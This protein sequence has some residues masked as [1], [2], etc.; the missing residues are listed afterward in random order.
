MA[1]CGITAIHDVPTIG[2]PKKGF[3][4][5]N[6]GR[7]F[8]MNPNHIMNPNQIKYAKT[9]EWVA[10]E[11]DLAIIGISDFAVKTLTDLVFLDLPAVGAKVVAGEPFGEVESVKAVSELISPVSGEVVETHLALSTSL[12]TLGSDPY[13]E[14]WLIKVRLHD[15]S[16]LCLLMDRAAYERQCAEEGH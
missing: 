1:W 12:D 3:Y 9:H 11:G 5:S 6:R 16:A 10:I 14:G 2:N 4:I 15:Q 7:I 8:N 13:G